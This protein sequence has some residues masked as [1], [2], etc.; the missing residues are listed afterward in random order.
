L[1][2]NLALL[3]VQLVLSLLLFLNPLFQ[4]LLSKSLLIIEAL[5]QAGTLQS[6]TCIGAFGANRFGRNAESEQEEGCF[7]HGS[8]LRH[9]AASALLIR[10]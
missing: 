8:S 3:F 2:L 1:L 4:L 10:I 5:I 6:S 9:H 7:H